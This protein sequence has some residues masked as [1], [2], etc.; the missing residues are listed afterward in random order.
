MTGH[1]LITVSPT[2]Y[3]N[4]QINMRWLE[5]F[6]DYYKCG[7]ESMWRILLLDGA[8]SHCDD[9]FILKSKMNKI[10]VI[11][12]RSHQ[13]HLIQP[14]DVGCFREWKHQQQLAIM[15]ALR[16]HEPEYNIR[17]FFRDLP[18]I[19]TN[20]FTKSNIKSAFKKSGM[21]PASFKAIK[22]KITEYGH[23][24]RKY[25]GLENLEFGSESEKDQ[26][27]EAAVMSEDEPG[28]PSAKIYQEK[29]PANY[30]E[31]ALG[32]KSLTDKVQDA[33]SSPS[34][35]RYKVIE[36]TAYV[37]LAHGSLHEIEIAQAKKGTV[38]YH[39]RKL[40]ARKSLSKGGSYLASDALKRIKE[41]RRT[42]ADDALKKAK[43]AFQLA[44][45]K[46][47][48]A[49]KNRGIATSKQETARK[50]AIKEQQQ[51][52]LSI[53]DSMNHPIRDPSKDTWPAE[54]EALRAN[55][56]L[57]EHLN[58][59]QREWETS[60][61]EN[62]EVFTFVAIDSR[63]LESDE[64]YSLRRGGLQQ[65]VIIYPEVEDEEDGEER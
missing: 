63:I 38:E 18:K 4:S 29:P 20:T 10:W 59:V 37:L 13:T 60:R 52:G 53:P 2:G 46:A 48:T 32:L 25:A 54:L 51:R 23:K 40:N 8:A 7:P 43:R 35:A 45:N 5:Y 9:E 39:K 17:S 47:K 30:Y 55:P 65:P 34:R 26:E 50:K 36:K 1:E 14:A 57:Y 15:D 21:W 56:S 28:L 42:E 19:R 11:F 62:P 22:A 33:L 44:E 6:I 64:Q 27:E 61:L 16:S 12:F 41:K 49:L 58:Q 31:T 24:K 3:T